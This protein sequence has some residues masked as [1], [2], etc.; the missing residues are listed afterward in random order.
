V[1]I[2]HTSSQRTRD[3]LE[4][5]FAVAKLSD[6][7]A[8]NIQKLLTM[9][10]TVYAAFVIF[11]DFED[12]D[13][14]VENKYY[15]DTSGVQKNVA[16][17]YYKLTDKAKE[18]ATPWNLF[19]IDFKSSAFPSA[20]ISHDYIAGKSKRYWATLIINPYMTRIDKLKE[21]ENV[22]RHVTEN[23][24]WEE[25]A[26]KAIFTGNFAQDGGWQWSIASEYFAAFAQKIE[27]IFYHKKVI[28]LQG[29]VLEA[30]SGAEMSDYVNDIAARNQRDNK[31]KMVAYLTFK[32]CPSAS[33]IETL[34]Q[35]AIQ[36]T[37]KAQDN[38][39]SYTGSQTFSKPK[40]YKKPLA[41]SVEIMVKENSGKFGQYWRVSVWV[42]FQD[43]KMAHAP[44]GVMLWSLPG[45]PSVQLQQPGTIGQQKKV[46]NNFASQAMAAWNTYS[47][48][49]SQPKSKKKPDFGRAADTGS[50]SAASSSSSGPSKK[51]TRKLKHKK[52]DSAPV[53]ELE[54]AAALTVEQ[55]E[56]LVQRLSAMEKQMVSRSE[57]KQLTTA[58]ARTEVTKRFKRFEEIMRGFAMEM[59]KIQTDLQDAGVT[60]SQVIAHLDGSTPATAEERLD[61]EKKYSFPGVSKQLLKQIVDQHLSQKALENLAIAEKISTIRNK[62]AGSA[63]RLST[64]HQQV[65]STVDKLAAEA[66]MPSPSPKVLQA[67]TS[68]VTPAKAK[69]KK[70]AGKKR[71]KAKEDATKAKLVSLFGGGSDSS[72]DSG[73]ETNV[74][75]NRVKKNKIASV[76]FIRENAPATSN[77]GGSTSK[78]NT[79]NSGGSK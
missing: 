60:A 76:T 36:A 23:I 34:K 39:F 59:S 10:N 57:C 7:A 46:T 6:Y 63:S 24:K 52:Q 69:G 51:A 20:K 67:K 33:E 54:N 78:S 14:D 8:G 68:T 29:N 49:S 1:E 58:A 13:G 31:R 28:D 61:L 44:A 70:P 77:G 3:L 2:T 71:Q 11:N 48:T 17:V 43:E 74:K 41:V 40:K 21:T 47:S 79:K 66:G 16:T 5:N 45:H 4:Q 38:V 50:S 18:S 42:K 73:S 64:V 65:I 72:S 75:A 25:G 53:E 56:R 62:V 30:Y 27:S 32:T 26:D 15:V 12:N 55:A 19:K 9:L 22:I 37:N 35:S